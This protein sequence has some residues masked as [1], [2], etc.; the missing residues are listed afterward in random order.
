ME[1]P[2]KKGDLPGLNKFIEKFDQKYL[3]RKTFVVDDA[4]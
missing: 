4:A 3:Y 1:S 2:G